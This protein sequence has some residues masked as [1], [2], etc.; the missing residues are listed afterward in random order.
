MATT[1]NPVSS[2]SPA[3]SYCTTMARPKALCGCPDC[4]SSLVQID[5]AVIAEALSA[6]TVPDPTLVGH[7]QPSEPWPRC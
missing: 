1:G 6:S 2:A 7:V 4:G 5:P 3:A